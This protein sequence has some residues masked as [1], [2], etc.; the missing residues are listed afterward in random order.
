MNLQYN[1]P[2]DIALG[3][4]RKEKSWKNREMQWSDLVVKLSTTH[5]TA[6]SHAEYL[7]SKK[8]RQD[9]I[10]DIGGFVGGYL[11]GGRR[12]AGNVSHRQLVTLDIDFATMD[13]WDAFC[14]SF[15][16]A[17]VIYSTHKHASDSPRLRLILPLDRAV[18]ADEYM[19]ISRKIAGILGINKFDHTTFQPERLMYWPSSSKD[20]DFVFEFQDGPWMNADEILSKY[21]DWK[22]TSEWPISDREQAIVKKGILK[23]GDPLE[24]PGIVGAFC[25]TYTIH[26][27][28][29]VFLSEV[30]EPCDIEDRYTY[31]EGSTSAG[32]V[33]YD[34]KF[35]YSHHGTDPAG[36]KLCNAFDLVRLHQFGLKDE[37]AAIDTPNNRLPSYLSMISLATSDDKVR[38]QIGREKLQD[39]LEDFEQDDETEAAE[40]FTEEDD[41][42]LEK[43]DVDGKGNYL[44]TINNVAVILENDPRLKDRFA[45]D[46]FRLKKIVCKS[47]PWRKLTP[48]SGYVKD[49]DEQNLVK[50]LEKF[51][52]ISSRTN[53]KDAFDTHVEARTQH[54]VR[55]YLQNLTWDSISRVDTLLVDYLGAEDSAYTR[56]VTR[57]ALVAAAAR[58]HQP[59][60][61][62]DYVLTLVG[63]QG[64]GK[65]SLIGKLGREWFSDS[66][67]F[68]MI[69]TKEA[70]EQLQG[71]WIIEFGELAGMRKADMEAAKHFISKREDSFRAAYARNSATHRRQCI[72]IAS[73]NNKGFLRDPTGNRRF[74]PVDT[75]KQRSMKDV[76]SLTEYEI[77]Q[78]WAEVM[79]FY[80]QGETLYLSVE[81]EAEAAKQQQEHSEMDERAGIVQRYLN[82]LLPENWKDMNLYERRGFLA[83]DELQEQGTVER[84]RVCAAE[85]WVEA[86]KGDIGKMDRIITREV[87]D[88]MRHVPGWKEHYT[89]M[90]FGMYGVQRGYLKDKNRVAVG[91]TDEKTVVAEVA[92]ELP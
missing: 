46:L 12:K 44:S 14:L 11:T 65:S 22:D 37:D 21:R 32:L 19:A 2:L 75:M 29:D 84:I 17:A 56:A 57:K 54:P 72:F 67:N 69:H 53:I 86:L 61:K 39:A 15:G 5:R 81:I 34:D 59:G 90:K 64:I 73:T 85:I 49:Q 1:G 68:G 27:V 48:G 89:K 7:A 33:V 83:G 52:G 58:V 66:F 20:G 10:K 23:Q 35:A 4:H 70:Y 51:Y 74:W 31:K 82:T 45:T 8:P 40:D 18:A 9:E 36:G 50:Y 71:A 80:R 30:Y 87:H 42:W 88:I 92:E 47:L 63:P 79:E 78:V 6:E 26:E 16:N 62:F 13:L 24:K 91:V 55:D 38:L 3:R 60:I 76:F 43:L 25:R 41:S 77:G 28:I